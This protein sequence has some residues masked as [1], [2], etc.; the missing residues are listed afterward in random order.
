VAGSTCTLPAPDA[1]APDSGR[2]GAGRSRLKRTSPPADTPS[3]GVSGRV[4]SSGESAPPPLS[5][6]SFRS[7]RDS[8][9]RTGR[10]VNLP[11]RAVDGLH[12]QPRSSCAGSE[13]CRGRESSPGLSCPN[14]V[15]SQAPMMRFRCFFWIPVAGQA[16]QVR[17]PPHAVREPRPPRASSTR[18]A[19]R[20]PNSSIARMTSAWSTAPMLMCAR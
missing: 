20:V 15:R 4:A 7:G 12:R 18:P 8:R 5:C 17:R 9:R 2:A 13:C 3:G 1:P 6:W 10:V 14:V 16:G 19:T 11:N